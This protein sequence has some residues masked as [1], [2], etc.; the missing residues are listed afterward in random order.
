MPVLTDPVVKEN[1]NKSDSSSRACSYGGFRC[2]LDYDVMEEK[3][4]G[5]H[6]NAHDR[7]R[8]LLIVLISAV[9]IVMVIA[10][11]VI[12]ESVRTLRSGTGKQANKVEQLSPPSHFTDRAA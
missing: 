11:G 10:V 3:R 1:Q 6:G 5:A 9:A 8:V 12:V 2:R 4:S 7:N